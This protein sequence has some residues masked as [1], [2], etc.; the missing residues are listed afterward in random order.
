[1]AVN[2]KK[3]D[4]AVHIGPPPAAESYL[5]GAKIIEAMKLTDAKAVHPG[6]GFL[7]EN[8]TFAQMCKDAG[9]IFIGPPPSAI[10]AMGSKSVSKKLMI[11]AGVPVTPG[12]HGDNQDPQLLKNE[13]NKIG[14]PVLIKAVSG[15]GGKG[16]RLV[17]KESEFLDALESCQRE[18][19]KSFSDDRVLLERFVQAPRHIE[20]QIFGDNHGNA[21][22]LFERDC[23]TQ[24]RHQKVLE[25]SP[26]PYLSQELRMKMGEAAVA[27]AKAVGYTGAG[28]VEFLFDTVSNEFFF[29]EMNT[30]L[31]VEHPV[32]EMVTGLV[33]T[34][35]VRPAL[36]PS[37]LV[38]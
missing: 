14:Y 4:E 12:Y 3:A 28:T 20:F 36:D 15:G 8:T 6:Y 26:A 5:L 23:S 1:L 10:T 30:R 13:A 27:A 38:V 25:E 7:S 32:T 19:L 17:W 31:Q 34:S 35:F 2:N 9:R 18:A 37:S 11:E 21:I 24:R 16:M 22:H 29:C 33:S